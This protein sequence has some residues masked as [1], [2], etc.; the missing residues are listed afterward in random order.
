VA[1]ALDQHLDHPP[2][3]E[4]RRPTFRESAKQTSKTGDE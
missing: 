1:D 4:D 2:D 3:V